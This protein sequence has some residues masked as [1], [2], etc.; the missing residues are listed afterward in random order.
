M[1]RSAIAAIS[2]SALTHNLARL[3]SLA[4]ASKLMAV[5][6]AD[7]YGHGLE[8]VA[9][10]LGSADAFGVAAIADGLRL[11]ASGHKQRIV[12]LSGIDE[13]N[14]LAEVRRLGLD[15]VLHH[16]EQLR[17]LQL[18][19]DPRPIRTWLKL[20]TGMHRLG[21]PS[22][23]A[24]AL[25]A[26]LR[27]ISQVAADLTVMTHFAN[28]DVPEDQS[29]AAQRAHFARATDPLGLP[30]SLANSAA[31]C[32]DP[33]SHAEWVR[34]GGLLYGLGLSTTQTGAAL[35][36]K[37]VMQLS[38]KLIAI[39][40]IAA[41]ERIGYAGTYTCPQRQRVGVVALGYGD[42]YPRQ[43]GTD[44]PVLLRG[45]RS[46]ILGRVSMDLMTI[47]LDAFP[48]AAIGDRVVLWGDELPVEEIA[49]AAG[50]I[51]YELTCGVTKRVMFLEQP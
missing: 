16:P 4:P 25:I 15:M 9:R 45:R 23:Q 5:V 29:N 49:T 12:V 1:S 21:F 48:D 35:G 40:D 10:A 13:P 36:F 24:T 42:G 41:G 37:P 8:R 28:S 17:M 39:Q 18:D 47:D 43:A 20:D 44:T 38:S 19:P 33:A 26:T 50:T 27:T 46:R 11:R 2:L 30:R 7:G 6:K 34:P 22:E 51:S 32:F 3:R 31:I 14:D